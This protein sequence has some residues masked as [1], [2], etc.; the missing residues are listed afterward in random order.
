MYKYDF[1][2]EKRTVNGHI[3]HRIRA[4]RDF[5]NVKKGDLGGF[6]ETWY[7][8][9]P[10]D[11]CWV[12]KEAC[13]YGKAVIRDDALITDNAIIG[14]SALVCDR[15]I[16]GGNAKIGGTSRIGRTA[17]VV[18]GLDANGGAENG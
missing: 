1:T 10:F 15:S 13:V 4:I 17:C 5:S 16:V 9:D 7:N 14:D 18:F 11:R 2:D 8:L 6:L 3:L 12:T